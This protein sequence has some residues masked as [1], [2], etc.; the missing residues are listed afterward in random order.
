MKI[1]LIDHD[2]GFTGS[3]I[4]MEYLLSYWL[5]KKYKIVVL[6]LKTKRELDLLNI[7]GFETK[8]IEFIQFK[9]FF[10]NSWSLDIHFTD[11]E[12]Y[13]SY[14]TYKNIL[15]LIL[16]FFYS[17]AY[18]LSLIYKSKPDIVYSNEFVSSA[19]LIVPSLLGIKTVCHVRGRLVNPDLGSGL[20]RMFAE[21][22]IVSFSKSVFCITKIEKDQF[23]YL[24]EDEKSK[25]QIVPE[26][27]N[28]FDFK[29]NESKSVNKEIFILL[30][31][32]VSKLKGTLEFIRSLNF[33]YQNNINFNAV[34]SGKIYNE[35]KDEKEY[36]D[37]CYKESEI[38]IGENMLK[39]VSNIDR[40]KLFND[41][42]I[43]VC[44]N[45]Q[46]HFSRPIIE[47][48][49][50]KIAVIAIKN[51]HNCQLIDEMEN[52]IIFNGTP[53][54]LYIKLAKIILE[55]DL[56]ISLANSGFNYAQNNFYYVDILDRTNSF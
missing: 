45:T 13:T 38:L 42:D 8:D 12:K 18:S 53:Y 54:D 32:G 19:F 6:T 3:T 27:L 55:K 25:L 34:I 47:A 20:I 7:S 16:K 17:L 39:I 48:W 49:A 50:K 15:I 26:F 23:I 30:A 52:G 5:E 56:R 11:S 4:S 43:L 10:I 28:H 37:L 36:Y 44:A 14:L 35:T 21:N 51:D 22:L 29:S 41:I 1:L 24:D 31:G 9:S 46:S 33:L 40:Q 2:S